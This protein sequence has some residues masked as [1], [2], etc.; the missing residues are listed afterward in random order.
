[1]SLNLNKILQIFK[2]L[3]KNPQSRKD[4]TGFLEFGVGYGIT[5]V[6]GFLL[7]RLINQSLPQVEI[8]KYSFVASLVG[9]LSPILYFAAPQAYLRFHENHSISKLLRRFLLPFYYFSVLVLGITIWCYTHSM[10]AVFYAAMPLF[11]EKTYLLRCQ[12]HITKL[13]ILKIAEL[14]LPLF[15]VVI[16]RQKNIALNADFIL[17]FYGLGYLTSYLFK[18]GKLNQSPIEKKTVLKFL[19]PTVF[20]AM[21]GMFITNSAVLFTK[22]F[23]GYEAAGIMGIANKSLL[24]LNSM[25]ALFLMF[26][27][28]IYIRE[29]EKRNFKLINIYRNGIMIIATGICIFFSIFSK[30]VYWLIGAKKYYAHTDLF[31]FLVWIAYFNFI[32]DIFW[33][34]FSYEIK[35]WKSTILKTIT[36]FLILAGI[37]FTSRYGIY[38]ITWVLLISVFLT[39]ITGAIWALNSEKKSFVNNSDQPQN[40]QP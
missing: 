37:V 17:F 4:I 10:L 22:H 32:A 28:M 7:V 31:V 24:F 33:L 15:L 27:P 6:V 13:N 29:A 35:T 3:L 11:T 1:M 16:C 38:Y 8:G 39:A 23:F 26:Y 20:T 34:Y 5:L 21:L 19:W 18:S 2:Q 36:V 40:N 30:A 12:M 9:L 25:F 14:L